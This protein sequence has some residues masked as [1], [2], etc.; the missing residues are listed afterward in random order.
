MQAF[1]EGTTSCQDG[2]QFRCSGGNWENVG[3][4]CADSD[5]GDAGVKVDPGVNEPKV[6]QPGVNDPSVKQ[7]AAP[8]EP[9]V[10]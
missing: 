5:P 8:A 7:P 4:N 3:T 2:R 9:K 6:R 1:S 10:P